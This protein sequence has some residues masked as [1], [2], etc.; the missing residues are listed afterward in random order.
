MLGNESVPRASAPLSSQ[1]PEPSRPWLW[2]GDFAGTKRKKQGAEYPGA[3][4]G[5]A[6]TVGALSLH[7]RA[8]WH[9]TKNTA[10]LVAAVRR[11]I[12]RDDSSCSNMPE[13]AAAICL[14]RRKQARRAVPRAQLVRA[15]PGLRA[16]PGDLR[17]E[18]PPPSTGDREGRPKP[19]SPTASRGLNNLL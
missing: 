15:A 10:L 7:S 9:K 4:P 3:S 1:S 11:G 13:T 8:S 5:P 6:N 2:L 19:V 16:R 14:M 12:Y 18:P 17:A